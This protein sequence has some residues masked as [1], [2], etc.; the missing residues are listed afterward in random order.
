[1][2]VGHNDKIQ[3]EPDKLGGFEGSSGQII[4]IIWPG[5]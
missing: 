4:I 2:V 1:M 3:R 5:N